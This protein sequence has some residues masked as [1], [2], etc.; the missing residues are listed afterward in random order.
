M[1]AIILA[2]GTSSRM[3][4]AKL[5]LEWEGK[6][7][8]FSLIKTVLEA[9]ITPIIVTGCYKEKIEKEIENI[10]KSLNVKLIK[11]H[12]KD[13][14]TGQ[15]SSL[16]CGVKKLKKIEKKEEKELPFFISVTDLPLL[17]PSNFTNM[18]SHL[19]NHDALRPKVGDTFG[20]PVLLNYYLKD[21][22]INMQRE[23]KKEGLRSFLK[24][25]DTLTFPS[26]DKAYITD[27]DTPESYKDLIDSL[28]SK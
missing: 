17:K 20:H 13:F 24:K 28:S 4:K 5:L 2:A 11:T 7:I 9:K 3:K 23:N 12:N 8:L 22:I 18:I 27:I 21:E 25:K 16:I 1:Y 14:E 10:E 26:D 6:T 15:L 19:K